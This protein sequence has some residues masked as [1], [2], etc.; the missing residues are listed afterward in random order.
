MRYKVTKKDSEKVQ[1]NLLQLI[2]QRFCGSNSEVGET[3][4]LDE[5]LRLRVAKAPNMETIVEELHDI[6]ASAWSSSFKIL[7]TTKK[8]STHKSVPWWTEGLTILRKKVNAQRRKYQRTRGNNDL[9][10]QRKSQHLATKA[11]CAATI[12]KERNASWR[13]FCSMASATNPWTG[14]YR[15][16]AGKRKQAAQITTLRKPDGTL[17]TNLHETLTH[18]IRYFTPEYNQND[19]SEYHK[20]LR[21]Q[22]QKSIVTPDDKEFTELEMKNAGNAWEI[23]RPQGRMG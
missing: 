21:A 9:R 3:E 14:T 19:D 15:L 2:E 17:T 22:T 6:L 23:I 1:V 13:E 7:R 16:A 4:E 8:A 5:T 11:E 12:K 18:M 20:Q 10:D